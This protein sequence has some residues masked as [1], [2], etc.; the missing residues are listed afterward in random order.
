VIFIAGHPS[1]EDQLRAL[2]VGCD[3]LLEWPFS[4]AL[5][6]AQVAALVRKKRQDDQLVSVENTLIALAQAVEAK[7]PYTQGHLERVVHYAT[8][9]AQ[10]VGLPPRNLELLRKACL[11]HDV[12]KIGIREGILLKPGPLT[13]EEFQEMKK[14]S[15]IGERIC[16]PLSHTQ[17][18]A[19]VVR[20]HHERYDGA[21]YPDSL[22]GEEIPLM[23]RIMAPV[24]AYDAL[25]SDRPYRR[26]RSREE[27]ITV[28]REESGRQFD[29]SLV[30]VFIDLYERH[31][32]P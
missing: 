22:A 26:R 19:D 15:T 2:E 8:L 7:D 29:P 23:A 21:G 14:H 3:H 17:V 31:A 11:L 13:Q 9:L 12:G 4:Q 27:A 5:L 24:D 6:L 1:L 25:T 18:I 16:R 20:H 10:E 30:L 28:L 32:L